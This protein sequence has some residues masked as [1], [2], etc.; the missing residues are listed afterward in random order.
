MLVGLHQMAA[1]MTPWM[2]VYFA[3]RHGGEELIGEVSFWVAVATPV[4]VLGAIP[5]RN[6]L[7]VNNLFS[8][9]YLYLFRL[10]YLI[11][12]CVLVMVLSANADGSGLLIVLLVVKFSELSLDIPLARALK[13]SRLDSIAAIFLLRLAVIGVS[14]VVG[15]INSSVYC[16]A[17][18]QSVGFIIISIFFFSAGGASPR[19]PDYFSSMTLGLSSF[20][21]AIESNIPR[22]ILGYYEDYR[23]LSLFVACAFV[24]TAVSVM[25]NVL[26]QARL[27]AISVMFHEGDL[28]GVWQESKKI[29]HFSIVVWAC[30]YGLMISPGVGSIYFSIYDLS[31]DHEARMIIYISSVI[32][33]LSIFLSIGAGL[34]TAQKSYFL[35]FRSSSVFSLIGILAFLGCYVF[36]GYVAGLLSCM[37]I[38]ASHAYYYYYIAFRSGR[39]LI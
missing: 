3:G 38:M 39:A 5:S 22:Y 18:S 34:V 29:L 14:Y 35:I 6:F 4:A 25:V 23:I 31:F 36:W 21:V 24:T 2:L 10:G 1:F 17:V 12:A 33:L 8:E 13:L 28:A 27:Y 19:M 30:I 7:L 11:T 16:F 37:A 9:S 26:V 32:C 20:V 15:S